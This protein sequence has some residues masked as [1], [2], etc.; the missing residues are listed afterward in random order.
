MSEPRHG[1]PRVTLVRLHIGCAACA[2]V[3][4]ETVTEAEVEAGTAVLRGALRL[5]YSAHVGEVTREPPRAVSTPPT[6]QILVTHELRLWLWEWLL[7]IAEDDDTPAATRAR[8][9]LL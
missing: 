3:M 7:T 4:E 6:Y 8:A 5:H 2:W 1:G 9:A